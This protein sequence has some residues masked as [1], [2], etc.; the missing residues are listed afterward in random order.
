LNNEEKSEMKTAV[1]AIKRLSGRSGV[2]VYEPPLES[3]REGLTVSFRLKGKPTSRRRRWLE[4]I[5]AGF[6]ERTGK[7]AAITPYGSR[8]V[9][10]DSHSIHLESTEP[11]ID[12]LFGIL[13]ECGVR[14]TIGKVLGPN[15]ER[16]KEL[17]K[18]INRRQQQI[19]Q[20]MAL[21]VLG[22][23]ATKRQR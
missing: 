12:G 9:G 8:W 23:A 7:W 1:R 11:T 2:E 17:R 3:R 4:G 5:A 22:S 14:P 18:S 21:R 13:E 15:R 6:M 10:W 20:R 16:A 19:T